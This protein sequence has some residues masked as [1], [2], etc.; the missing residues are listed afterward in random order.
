V[1][2]KLR[3]NPFSQ[4]VIRHTAG[5]PTELRVWSVTKSRRATTRNYSKS[6]CVDFERLCAIATQART[7]TRPAPSIEDYVVLATLGLWAP[8]A[9]LIEPILLEAPIR[10]DGAASPVPWPDAGFALRGKVWLQ[11]G[12]EPCAPVGDIS[13]GCLSTARPILWHKGS[14]HEPVFPWWPDAACLVAL[15]AVQHGAP[16]HPDMLPALHALADQGILARLA[17]EQDGGGSYASPP[18]A[19][20]DFFAREGFV[21]LPQLLPPGQLAAFRRYWRK[22]AALDVLPERGDK[23]HGSHGEPS[24]ML[25]LLLLLPLVEFL[26]GTPLE[27]A[28]SYSWIYGRDTKMPSHRD[29]AESRYTVSLLI[30]Y[31]PESDGP[32]P[33][34]IFV[35]PRGQSAPVE[36]RQSVGNALLFCGEELEHF[37]PPF[38]MGD[39]STSLLLHYV[40]KGFSGK[41][42]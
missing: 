41:L 31:S 8:E 34:P 19:A 35:S 28:F 36:I 22:L 23:R 39:R 3:P 13:L 9:D 25:L 17:A 12:P 42:F 14:D 15:D 27:P 40:D 2:A 18:E 38:T 32:T 10:S 26:V 20:R 7:S 6:T 24:S 4:V 33:W 16:L 21:A 11:N 37:R 5:E 30:D 29:R 1:S